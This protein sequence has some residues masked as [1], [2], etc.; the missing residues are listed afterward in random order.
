MMPM[1]LHNLPPIHQHHVTAALWHLIGKIC[2]VYIDDIMIS[3][4][5]IEDHTGDT[6]LVLQA[7]HNASLYLNPKKC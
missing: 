6:W 2:H 5:S 7:L 4:K 1:G 3:S